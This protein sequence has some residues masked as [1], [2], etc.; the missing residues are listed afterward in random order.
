MSRYFGV[1]LLFIFVFSSTSYSMSLQQLINSAKSGSV[2]KLSKKTT[3]KGGVVIN[4]SITLDCKGATIDAMGKGDV[5]S[6]INA[7]DVTVENCVLNNS[8]SSGWKMDAG[9]KLVGAKNAK[10]LN[11]K[12]KNCLYGIVA[13]SSTGVLIKNNEIESKPYSEGMKG[14][15]IRLW[16]CGNSKIIGNYIHDS[17]DVVSI[18]SNNVVFNSNRVKNSHIGIMIQNSN[19]NKIMNFSSLDN[20][21][22]ILVNSSENTQISNFF[23]KDKGKYRGIVLVEASNTRIENGKIERCKKGLVFNL[24]PAKK[25]TKNYV[26]KVKFVENKIGVYSHTTAKQRRRNII[27]N[28]EY[29]NNRI[30]FMDELKSHK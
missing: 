25:G 2:I 26:N 6:I 20:E 1:L 5:V 27:E 10:I 16:W 7:S 4:K 11:D 18:F 9:I 12:I 30:N 3:Y 24:S 13:K 17:S 29:I 28:V 8:G 14:D 22:G 23:I 19:N 15:S 21:V